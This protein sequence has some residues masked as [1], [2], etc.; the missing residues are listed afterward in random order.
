MSTRISRGRRRLLLFV[1][2]AAF[3]AWYA[4]LGDPLAA[5]DTAGT[6]NV[7]FPVASGRGR[8]PDIE[9]L[10][11]RDPFSGDPAARESSVSAGDGAA[12]AGDGASRADA[13]AG[14]A[15]ASSGSGASQAAVPDIVPAAMPSMLAQTDGGREAK[16]A[17]RATIT[18]PNP[19]AYI[20]DGSDMQ[21]VRVGDTLGSR[22]VA[23]IDL[24]GV[25]FSDGTRLDLAGSGVAAEPTDRPTRNPDDRAITVRDLK[26]YLLPPK[27]ATAR[28]PAA[29]PVAAPDTPP[30]YRLEGATPESPR[31]LPTANDQGLQPGEN[32]TP[33]LTAPTAFPYPY[34]YP[35]PYR[36]HR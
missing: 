17:L 20:V 3:T 7:A 25:V 18:G 6:P 27:G 16:L 32:P 12:S 22:R 31:P 24:R 11:R 13:A 4:G 9:A 5:Q 23:A 30:P 33:N 19:V 10:I 15:S 29:T 35:P 2:A 36:R 21:I 28:V 34:P 8:A 14:R 1:S 26:R